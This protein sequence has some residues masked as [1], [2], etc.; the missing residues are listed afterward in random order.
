MRQLRCNI[1]LMLSLLALLA[2][3]QK[4]GADMRTKTEALLVWTGDPNSDAGCGYFIKVNDDEF[5]AENEVLIPEALKTKETVPVSIVFS[6]IN[7]KLPYSCS[8]GAEG[9]ADG[10]RIFSIQKKQ[11]IVELQTAERL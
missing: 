8:R 6:R 9:T 2:S 5:K 10:I 11:A 3:C 1:L 4:E 7:K